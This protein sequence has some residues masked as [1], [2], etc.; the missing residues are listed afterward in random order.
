[1]V[2]KYLPKSYRRLKFSKL[3]FSKFIRF[4]SLSVCGELQFTQIL[5][6][7]KSFCF[8]LKIK[9]KNRKSES[10]NMCD[11]SIDLILKGTITI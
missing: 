7:F 5:L 1:M 4:V 9:E 10:K 6:N 2:V 8:N 3:R 11:F